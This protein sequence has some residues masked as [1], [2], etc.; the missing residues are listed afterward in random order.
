MNPFARERLAE[1]LEQHADRIKPIAQALPAPS[2]VTAIERDVIRDTIASLTDR[3]MAA[4]ARAARAELRAAQA[5]ADAT[6]LRALL[7]RLRTTLA[8]AT[9]LADPRA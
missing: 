5:E 7:S 4:E 2:S 1:L 6:T 3:A 9:T 8:E